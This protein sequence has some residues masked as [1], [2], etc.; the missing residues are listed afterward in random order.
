MHFIVIFLLS[1]VFGINSLICDESCHTSANEV[2]FEP[3]L[4]YLQCLN[5]N[6]LVQSK[7][8]NTTSEVIHPHCTS[9]CVFVVFGATGDLTARKLLPAIYNLAYDGSLSKFAVIG[10]ARSENTHVSFRKNMEEAIEQFSRIKPR[11][12]AFWNHFKNQIFYHQ[13]EFENDEDY[14][15]LKRFLSQIDQELGTQGNRIFYLATQPSYFLTIITKLKKYGLIYE[16]DGYQIPWSRVIIEKPFGY[17]L[18]SALQLQEQISQLLDESQVYRMDH[19]LGKEGVQNLLTLRFENGIFEPLWNH[20]YIDNIQITLAEEIGIGSRAQLWEETGTLRDV[21]QNHLMQL[22]A[23]IAMEVP[24]D[25]APDSIHKGKIQVLEAIRPFP[26]IEMENY[27][28]RGQ[29]G[30]GVIKGSRVV[31][32]REELG[33]LPTSTVETF[34]ALKLFIDNERWKGVPFYIRGGKRLAKQTTEIAI[35]FKANPLFQNSNSNILF[36]RIQPNA[37]I[38]LQTKSKVPG[39]HNDLRSVVFGYQP[40]VV[41]GRS[42]PEA[43]ERMLFDCIKGDDSLF[44]KAEEQIMAWRLLMPVLNHWKKQTPNDFPNY[45]AG[46]WGPK[47]ADQMLIN[48]GHQWQ[49]LEFSKQ[50]LFF[51]SK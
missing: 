16:V 25:L 11:D 15:N 33:V 19:Y 22:L 6:I 44:V 31:G 32:Y 8:T 9:P 18:D 10:F 3:P 7:L 5:S 43:Y 35:T 1:F 40:D 46:T 39:L 41:F 34:A 27:V 21:F 48:Q 20:H 42:S 30:P 28:I 49:L 4:T 50:P 12:L 45:E 37:G 26:L 38:F 51:S 36:I 29:Y 14:E 13:S 24:A 47:A 2:N 17:D 23:L